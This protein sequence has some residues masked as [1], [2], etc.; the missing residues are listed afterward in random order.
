MT[1][2]PCSGCDEGL[3]SAF[4]PPCRSGH[5][6][7][8]MSNLPTTLED[9]RARRAIR[10][11]SGGARAHAAARAHRPRR[12][13]TDPVGHHSPPGLAS[14]RTAP[15]AAL[16]PT[17]GPD[18]PRASGHRGPDPH[19]PPKEIRQQRAGEDGACCPLARGL[20]RA[21]AGAPRLLEPQDRAVRS[22]CGRASPGPS[23]SPGGGRG[24]R[25]GSHPRRHR[26]SCNPLQCWETLTHGL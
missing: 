14:R 17:A 20:T 25:V 2:T 8:C 23:V 4:E 11:P 18:A 1:A 12:G 15:T 13:W 19:P 21:G 3:A 7:H 22:R 9:H 26:P 5:V 6:S 16:T 10:A 24:C